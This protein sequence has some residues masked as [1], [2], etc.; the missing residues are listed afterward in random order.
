MEG[1]VVEEGEPDVPSG[2]LA[3]LEFGAPLLAL[4]HHVFQLFTKTIWG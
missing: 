3:G 2:E 1:L 4:V